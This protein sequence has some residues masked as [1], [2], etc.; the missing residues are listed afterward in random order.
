[1]TSEKI[2]SAALMTTM[3]GLDRP[4]LLRMLGVQSEFPFVGDFEDVRPINLDVAT[5]TRVQAS[6]VHVMNYGT[7]VERCNGARLVRFQRKT[8]AVPCFEHQPTGGDVFCAHC[9]EL[10]FAAD[11][12]GW[13]KLAKRKMQQAVAQYKPGKNNLLYRLPQMKEAEDMFSREMATVRATLADTDVELSSSWPDASFKDVLEAVTVKAGVL[14][15]ESTNPV[16]RLYRDQEFIG[17]YVK[18]MVY[19]WLR[20]RA[21]YTLSHMKQAMNTLAQRAQTIQKAARNV[22]QTALPQAVVPFGAVTVADVMLAGFRHAATKYNELVDALHGAN[23]EAK[24]PG[25]QL[26][27]GKKVAAFFAW[28][29]EVKTPKKA[30]KAPAGTATSETA[31]AAQ[32]PAAEASPQAD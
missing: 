25:P 12:R 27:W 19:H 3:K 10:F 21:V 15:K 2:S 6:E 8:I 29:K 26:D 4:V 32:T 18:T 5:N 28:A 7:S 14:V 30:Q 20:L 23:A 22:L 16:R 9:A 13:Y 31:A 17:M 1:M 11:D 24:R